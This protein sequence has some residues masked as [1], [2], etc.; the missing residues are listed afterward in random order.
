LLFKREENTLEKGEKTLK[1]TLEKAL[2]CSLKNFQ[3][4]KSVAYF[5]SLN[6]KDFEDLL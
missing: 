2:N 6:K 1:I 5:S 4:P 3:E